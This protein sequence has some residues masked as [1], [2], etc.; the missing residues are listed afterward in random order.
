MANFGRLSGQVAARTEKFAK[1]INRQLDRLEAAGPY[2]S[3][4]ARDAVAG[5][6][7]NFLAAYSSKVVALTKSSKKRIA[8][9]GSLENT[10]MRTRAIEEL[11]AQTKGE[12]AQ[13]FDNYAR[14]RIEERDFRTQAQSI[15]R[16]GAL[17]AA[18]VG[19]GG[20]G[21]L[22]QNILTAVQRQ[23]SRQF[24][25]LDGFINEMSTRE[26]T[27]RDRARTLQYGNFLHSV[28]VNAK[29][30]MTLDNADDEELEERR[31]LGAAEHCEDCI[32][33]ASEGWVPAGTLPPIGVDT[34]CGDSCRCTIET[35]QV[36]ENQRQSQ[37]V[38][39]T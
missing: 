39:E 24:N 27:Q 4:A 2:A 7:A 12:L 3:Y 16:R 37:P 10:K 18:I 5:A 19:V 23:V 38:P 15:I 36:P 29:R 6:V 1:R 17:A 20:V 11:Q 26:L 35:R 21:E 34:R 13:V 8:D 31:V 25:L 9:M 28:A 30:Q 14:G 22:T 32:A 33:L